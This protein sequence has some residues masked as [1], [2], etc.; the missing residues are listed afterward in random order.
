VATKFCDLFPDDENETDPLEGG[1]TP[2][3]YNYG[4][5]YKL[6]CRNAFNLFIKN[7]CPQSYIETAEYHGK[8]LFRSTYKMIL[9]DKYCIKNY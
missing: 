7:I 9:E 1:M 5:Y 6:S 3:R 2:P 8:L 4:V